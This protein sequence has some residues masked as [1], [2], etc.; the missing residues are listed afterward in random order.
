MLSAALCLLP[1]TARAA[2]QPARI[3]PGVVAERVV[4]PHDT[5]Q[6]YAAYLPASYDTTRAWPVLFV[7]DPRGRA[8]QALALFREAAERYGYIV[9]SS[10]NTLSDGPAEP[11]V[12]AMNAMLADV[13][14]S[15]RADT[16]RFYL[17]GFSGTARIAWDFAA[18]MDGAVAG[19]YGTG[20]SAGALPR[21]LLPGAAPPD[22]VFFGAAGT[23][24]FNYEE[25]RGFRTLL[26]RFALPH[27]LRFFPGPHMWPPAA[28]AAEALG[29]FELRA[30]HSGLRPMDAALV[31]SLFTADTAAARALETAG[32]G[33]DALARWR[34]V[35]ADYAG[36]RHV[37]AAEA[38]ISALEKDRAVRRTLA[39]RD[40][41]TRDF[42]RYSDRLAAWLQR[43]RDAQAP[44]SAGIRALDVERL[45]EEAAQREEAAKVD[46]AERADAAQRNLEQ[47]FVAL[48]FYEPRAQL[49]RG[50]AAR[51][52]LFLDVAD[53]IKPGAPGVQL[54]RARALVQLDRTE[55][56]LTALERA[57]AGGVAP[58]V[59][60][61]DTAFE[62]LRAH[63]RFRALVGR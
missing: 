16:R 43:A 29:W 13:Q 18:Q 62:T 1:C 9:L 4:S 34:E 7:M 6:S 44:P 27:R 50:D 23:T 47:A 5:T 31:D 33:A 8:L 24:D 28:I 51:A 3:V 14:G 10:Y 48:S 36:L 22:V 35:A 57:V 49:E 55:E 45:R 38:R 20:A 17:A 42:G 59:L 58:T 52:L 61:G 32:H 56:A 60:A 53:A 15:F 30:L 11:N 40:E 2:A 26:E 39:R 54:F 19:I 25:V 12:H 37:G 21:F 46:D 63:P 41:F